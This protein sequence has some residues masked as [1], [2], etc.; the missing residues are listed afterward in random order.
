LLGNQGAALAGGQIARGNLARNTF[1]DV[2]QMAGTAA[3]VM[4]GGMG[5]GLGSLFGGGATQMPTFGSTPMQTLTGY[6]NS[7][8][9][10]GGGR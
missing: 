6:A 9:N 4:G 7:P 5:G 8:I 1:G 2:A 3:A 10:L